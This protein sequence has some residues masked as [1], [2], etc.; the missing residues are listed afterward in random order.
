ME[1][2]GDEV[3]VIGQKI[4]EG[5]REEME[6]NH[7]GELVVID[8]HSGDYEVGEFV[9]RHSDLKIT[10]RLLERHPE[11]QTWAELVG[12]PAPYYRKEGKRGTFPMVAERNGQ[13]AND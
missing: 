12:Y 11:A 8:V 6:A 2:T 10:D 9:S 4:Y 13:A 3:A 7:W 5:I 1:I